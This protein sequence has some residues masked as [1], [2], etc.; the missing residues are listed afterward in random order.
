M[1]YVRSGA[2]IDMTYLVTHAAKL[3]L[4]PMELSSIWLPVQVV[5]ISTCLDGTSVITHGNHERILQAEAR[6]CATADLFNFLT[7]ICLD[8]PPTPPSCCN[9]DVLAGA[10]TMQCAVANA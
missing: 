5:A 6:R 9:F 4:C 1:E 8:H 2:L 10:F 3:G 7:L